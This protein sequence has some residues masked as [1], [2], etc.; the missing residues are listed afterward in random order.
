MAASLLLIPAALE[1]QEYDV[2]QS[3]TPPETV[4]TPEQPQEPVVV[5]PVV[6]PVSDPVVEP[7][8]EEVQAVPEQKVKKAKVKK[9]TVIFRFSCGGLVPRHQVQSFYRKA[10][11]PPCPTK[12][13]V[14]A[15]F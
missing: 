1:A 3:Q 14:S 8:P 5:D 11:L 2:P 9:A 15:D 10:L 6:V 7:A 13:K 4:V 12:R